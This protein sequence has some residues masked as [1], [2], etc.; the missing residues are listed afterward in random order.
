MWAFQAALILQGA[1]E[2]DYA[3]S[4]IHGTTTCLLFSFCSA[5]VLRVQIDAIVL[6][7]VEICYDTVSYVWLPQCN[8]KQ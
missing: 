2:H 8:C 7:F 5:Y 6:T 4:N 3:S 1:E